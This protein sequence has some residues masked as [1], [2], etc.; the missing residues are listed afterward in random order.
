MS[1][2]IVEC[3]ARS[4]ETEKYTD[5]DYI[6]LLSLHGELWFTNRFCYCLLRRVFKQYWR[7]ISCS[8]IEPQKAHSAQSSKSYV[9]VSVL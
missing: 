7:L 6:L 9:S 4:A 8:W 5:S 1:S 2:A 3:D